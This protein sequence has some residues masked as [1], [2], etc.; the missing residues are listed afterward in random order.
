MNL[1]AAELPAV[2]TFLGR[3]A[4]ELDSVAVAVHDLQGFP[5]FTD[6]GAAA[7]MD[8]RLQALDELSQRIHALALVAARLADQ[9]DDAVLPVPALI[10]GLTLSGLAARLSGTKPV[11]VEAGGDFEMF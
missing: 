2:S 1:N 4:H 7:R 10:R 8:C 6:C 9:V 3:F 5:A 11:A